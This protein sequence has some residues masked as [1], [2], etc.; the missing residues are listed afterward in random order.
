MISWERTYTSVWFRGG[1]RPKSGN[2]FWPSANCNE[3][4]N[5][6]SPIA[7]RPF[8]QIS[9]NTNRLHRRPQLRH[10]LSISSKRSSRFGCDICHRTF[11]ETDIRDWAT[12]RNQC[13]YVGS[14]RL[15]RLLAR[16]WRIYDQAYA[17]TD[18]DSLHRWRCGHWRHRA[19]PTCA[20]QRRH[21][22][23]RSANSEHHADC[24]GLSA[25]DSKVLSGT[26]SRARSPHLPHP[27]IVI[28]TSEG[29]KRELF[30]RLNVLFMP[31]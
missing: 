21:R 15:Q 11:A 2:W 25:G 31:Q 19:S 13:A 24:E 23:L 5:S 26:N 10:G 29:K 18:Y 20:C 1:G 12:R 4:R 14:S 30:Q 27:P 22:S 6:N 17:K 9:R 3:M 7:G 28:E 16:F 8:A